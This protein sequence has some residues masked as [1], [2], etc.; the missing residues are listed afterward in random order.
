MPWTG[1]EPTGLELEWRDVWFERYWRVDGCLCVEKREVTYK[2]RNGLAEM[3]IWAVGRTRESLATNR[4][5]RCTLHRSSML[6]KV[7]T[8]LRVSL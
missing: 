4:R 8:M 1:E 7:I 6:T 2:K 5:L 3:I